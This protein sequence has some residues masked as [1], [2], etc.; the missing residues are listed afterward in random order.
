M[1]GMGKW[2]TFADGD[3]R[4]SVEVAAE[5]PGSRGRRTRPFK[6]VVEEARDPMVEEEVARADEVE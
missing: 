4:S 3:L 6:S 5:V 2:R 1:G